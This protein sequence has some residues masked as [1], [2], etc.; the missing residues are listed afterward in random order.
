MRRGGLSALIV[1]LLAASGP[2]CRETVPPPAR[3]TVAFEAPVVTLDPHAHSHTITGAVLAHFYDTLVVLDRDLRLHPRLARSWVTPSETLWRFYLREDVVFHDGRRLTATDVVAALRRAVRDD[4][5]AAQYLRSVSEVR[6]IGETVLEVETRSPS[7]GLLNRLAFVSITPRDAPD[8]IR[9]PV[10]TGPYRFV[11]VTDGAIEA[12]RFNRFWGAPPPFET[13]SFAAIPDDD[14]RAE[15]I[16]RGDADIVCQY[17]RSRWQ[18]GRRQADM[19]VLSVDGLQA[20]LLAFS[21]ADGSPFADPRLRQAVAL[22]VD[23][24][25]LVAEALGGLG[26]PLDQPVPPL[27]LGYSPTLPPMLH[28]PGRARRLVSEAGFSAGAGVPIYSAETY[29]SIVRQLE[30]QLES[31]GI[32]VEPRILPQADLYRKLESERVPAA[33]FSWSAG[34]GDASATLDPLF[35]TPG[36]GLGGFNRWSYSSPVFDGL[37][38]RAD[39]ASRPEDRVRLCGSAMEVLREDLPAVP[40]TTL[41]D[42]YAVRAG[43]EWQPPSHRYLRVS[44]VHRSGDTDPRH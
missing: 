38:D 4:R 35:H 33:V 14:R 18:W 41:A 31:V 42:L 37:I 15:A 16:P 25:R 28:N 34:T 1:I 19:R 39:H 32:D 9:V 23:R 5:S 3:L 13:V 6:A 21:M 24:K 11:A 20:V 26:T 27:V 17:P 2:A 8:S 36:A 44:E 10:G 29:G 43:L 22:A 40:L 30:L 7:L 12:R